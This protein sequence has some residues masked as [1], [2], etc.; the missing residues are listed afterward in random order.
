MEKMIANHVVET[1]DNSSAFKSKDTINDTVETS[2]NTDE[3]CNFLSRIF[4]AVDTETFQNSKQLI[5][6]KEV[7]PFSDQSETDLEVEEIMKELK[8]EHA[9]VEKWRDDQLNIIFD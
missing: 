7:L 5:Q 6:A 2:N 4:K 8:D 1:V 9:K 3:K